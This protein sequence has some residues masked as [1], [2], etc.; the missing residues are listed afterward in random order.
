MLSNE[1]EQLHHEAAGNQDIQRKIEQIEGESLP[2]LESE[3]QRV[4]GQIR[5]L[6]EMIGEQNDIEK[7]QLKSKPF[8][9]KGRACGKRLKF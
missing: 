3:K 9:K 6:V 8:T 4:L 2:D 1:L 7:R 5:E